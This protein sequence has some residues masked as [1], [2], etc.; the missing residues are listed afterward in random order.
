MSELRGGIGIGI[1]EYSCLYVC[2]IRNWNWEANTVELR[3]NKSNTFSILSLTP[4]YWDESCLTQGYKNRPNFLKFG[5]NRWNRAGP[6]LK[7][8]EILFTVSKFQKKI[9][10]SEE[11]IYVKTRS[12]S[13]VTG[14]EIFI[15]PGRLGW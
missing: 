11:K 10:K 6:N 2:G 1:V 14:E 9:K 13:N 12:N 5:K 7:T 3:H 4:P 8:T 15:K